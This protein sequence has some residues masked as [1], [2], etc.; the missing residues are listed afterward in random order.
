M[1]SDLWPLLAIAVATST[2]VLGLRAVFREH[3]PL[4]WAGLLGYGYCLGTL[5]AVLLLWLTG[6][7]A[8]HWQPGV[9]LILLGLL[10][11]VFGGLGGGFFRRPLL[12]V[13]LSTAL[14][15]SGWKRGATATL[16]AALL[17]VTLLPLLQTLKMPLYPWDA[18]AAWAV[19]AKAWF[20]TN[21]PLSFVPIGDWLNQP[22]AV[23]Y[24]NYA[25]DYPGLLPS[26]QL[27]SVMGMSEWQD[28]LAKI[29]WLACLVALLLAV[30]GG[31]RAQGGG[32]WL[33]ALGVYF[34]ASLPL[35]ATHV[36]LAGYADLWIGTFLLLTMIALHRGFRDEDFKTLALGL[37]MA[38]VMPFFKREGAIWCG[39]ILAFLPLAW[40]GPGGQSARLWLRPP[41]LALGAVLA[42]LLAVLTW[43][44]PQSLVW[45]LPFLG[46]F[47][48]G[49]GFD[50]W[51][52]GL[53]L[54]SLDNWHLLWFGVPVTLL[55]GL[56]GLRHHPG[57]FFL[58]A[59]LGVGLGVVFLFFS[60]TDY[61]QFA[62]SG[63]ALDRILLQLAPLAIYQGLT[64]FRVEQGR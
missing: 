9:T 38:L 49:C 46:T 62:I 45:S 56:T 13:R 44:G 29:P 20:G 55:A 15:S 51:V 60:C 3:F 33:A 11:L 24:T 36:V 16:I 35:L 18:W 52:W 28:G 5:L 2:G 23:V 59:F 27:W 57:V 39:L 50:T 21:Q 37:L 63:T 8:G 1:N 10:G 26:I 22:S 30:Y 58:S 61:W 14:P 34:M 31:L 6:L 54:F 64:L 19:K 47:A 7:A 12:P 4:G 48:L 17:L 25:Q 40:P 42:V 41:L 53:H 43:Q 32:I